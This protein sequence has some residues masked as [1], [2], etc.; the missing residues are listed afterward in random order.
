MRTEHAAAWPPFCIS[1]RYTVYYHCLEDGITPGVVTPAQERLK[2]A[3]FFCSFAGERWEDKSIRRYPGAGVRCAWL[4][5][6][7]Q[8][9]RGRRRLRTSRAPCYG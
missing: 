7:V 1:Y 9:F 4:P 2:H 5:A 6:C 8:S 3:G